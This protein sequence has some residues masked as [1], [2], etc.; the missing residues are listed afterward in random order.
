MCH[1]RLSS[2]GL[3]LALGL[4]VLSGPAASARQVWTGPVIQYRQ[5]GFDPT[6]A[7]NQ[8]RLTGKVWL[9][10]AKTRGLFNAR[11]ESGYGPVSPA[12]TEWAYGKL[13]DYA[14]LTYQPWETWNGHFPPSMVGQ[15]AVLHLISEDIY[16]AITFDFWGRQAHA[17]FA[18]TRSTPPLT[19]VDTPG[20]TPPLAVLL[21]LGMA[22]AGW[23]SLRPPAIAGATTAGAGPQ[24]GSSPPRP[25]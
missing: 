22:A 24:N 8:D 6:L 2:L 12:D 16:L 19:V 17:G 4:P 9:S 14:S 21:A 13:A 3:W 23:R 20:L 5:P 10:R 25:G 7:T 18:Y 11:T 1:H 15:E